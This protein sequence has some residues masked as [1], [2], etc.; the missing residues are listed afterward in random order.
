MAK[1]LKGNSEWPR[2][3]AAFDPQDWGPVPGCDVAGLP[4]RAVH[5]AVGCGFAV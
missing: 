1:F 2:E 3:L 5:R 4:V